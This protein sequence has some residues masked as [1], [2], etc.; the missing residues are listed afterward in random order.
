[1]GK[2]IR[3]ATYEKKWDTAV[4][5]VLALNVSVF[6]IFY[7]EYILFLKTDLINGTLV[8][9]QTVVGQLEH[10][11]ILLVL[12]FY[13]SI[14]YYFSISYHGTQ[15]RKYIHYLPF[16]IMMM[17]IKAEVHYKTHFLAFSMAV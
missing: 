6:S 10:L 11:Y 5:R 17:I 12:W 15:P 7:N 13:E 4:Y 3:H 1:M 2:C 9:N 16:F 14:I 8:N